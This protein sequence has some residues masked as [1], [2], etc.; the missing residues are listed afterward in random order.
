MAPSRSVQP[1]RRKLIKTLTTT[2]GAVVAARSLP[3]QWKAPIVQSIGLPAHAQLTE[4]YMVNGTFGA[5]D[6]TGS[7]V[8]DATPLLDLIAPKAYAGGVAESDM[9]DICMFIDDGVIEAL[10]VDYMSGAALFP[11]VGLPVSLGDALADG[12]ALDTS[13]HANANSGEVQFNSVNGSIDGSVM[14]VS[15]VG[16]ELYDFPFT[17]SD[18]DCEFPGP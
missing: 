3:D 9:L 15:S 18:S 6:F 8:V 1:Q 7:A 5:T 13:S 12:I 11:A 14:L 16:E 17:A 2:A 10:F 4:L